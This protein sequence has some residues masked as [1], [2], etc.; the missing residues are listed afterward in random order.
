MK[1]VEMDRPVAINSTIRSFTT[2]KMCTGSKTKSAR[3]R[4]QVSPLRLRPDPLVS[5]V[6]GS[7]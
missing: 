5:L 2:G 6:H 4:M 3:K 7:I 1:H